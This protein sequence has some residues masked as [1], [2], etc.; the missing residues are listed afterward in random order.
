MSNLVIPCTQAEKSALVQIAYP[1]RVGDWAMDWLRHG[2]TRAETCQAPRFLFCD[3]A[4]DE[5]I[6]ILHTQ[7]PRFLAEAVDTRDGFICKVI[8]EHEPIRIPGSQLTQ[9]LEEMAT[10]AQDQL[11]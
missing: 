8:E 7:R 11:K 10:F 5:R 9:L 6:F 3:A 1:S 4:G 2:L